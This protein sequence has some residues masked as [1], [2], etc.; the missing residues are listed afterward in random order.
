[1][2]NLTRY[3]ERFPDVLDDVKTRIGYRV[4]PTLIWSYQKDDRPGLVVGLINDGVAAVPGALRISVEDSAG[5]HLDGGNL[6]PG[7]PLP[8]KIR[9]AQLLMPPGTDWQGLRLLP[10]QVGLYAQTQPGRNTDTAPKFGVVEIHSPTRVQ[11]WTWC[12]WS[13]RPHGIRPWLADRRPAVR[14]RPG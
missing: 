1:V 9:Q 8:G 3:T 11:R 2:D 13:A 5:K 12:R 6:D 10:G 7:Y 4:R 14:P